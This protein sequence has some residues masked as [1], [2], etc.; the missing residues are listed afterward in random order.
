[1]T[2]HN[3]TRKVDDSDFHKKN[4]GSKP[5]SNS[6]EGTKNFENGR[7]SSD[8]TGHVRQDSTIPKTDSPKQNNA[9]SLD[10]AH[11]GRNSAPLS[12]TYKTEDG[13][14]ITATERMDPAGKNIL[15][16]VDGKDYVRLAQQDHEGN[17]TYSLVPLKEGKPDGPEIKLSSIKSGGIKDGS[18][19]TVQEILAPQPERKNTAE[20]NNP[21]AQSEG[22]SSLSGERV[23]ESQLN[24]EG[25]AKEL[26]SPGQELD[27]RK[28]NSN[29]T[30][31]EAH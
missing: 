10:Q 30:S 24:R 23:S 4:I 17:N 14:N 5:S 21:K 7:Q 2:E 28:K 19:R 12:A 26:N 27:L 25:K 6:V 18:E 8:Q 13:R 15:A 31:P 22:A 16:N 11:L 9:A 3:L 1:M 29:A 20:S